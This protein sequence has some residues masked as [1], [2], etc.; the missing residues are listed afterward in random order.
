MEI[1]LQ[2]QQITP[3]PIDNDRVISATI[4]L[5]KKIDEDDIE[6]NWSEMQNAYARLSNNERFAID[7]LMKEKAPNSNKSYRNLL[8][9]Y[10]AYKPTPSEL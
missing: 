7:D 5:K 1:K 3:D 8:K 4:W 10:L 2:T 6:G 9:E